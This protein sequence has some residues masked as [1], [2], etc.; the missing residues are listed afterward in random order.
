MQSILKTS[1]DYKQ[2]ITTI[3]WLGLLSSVY[4]L[5]T[6][7]FSFGVLLISEYSVITKGMS[8]VQM[9]SFTNRYT[10]FQE[11]GLIPVYFVAIGS[12]ITSLGLIKRKEWA[13]IMSIRIVWGI[14]A[15]AVLFF[16]SK[17]SILSA[18]LPESTPI[19]TE[20]DIIFSLWGQFTLMIKAGIVATFITYVFS[21]PRFKSCF[22]PGEWR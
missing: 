4:F 21:I 1:E 11:I 13:R 12:L 15:L 9:E 8:N 20:T 17:Y 14:V 16:A 19:G 2:L 18:L 6:S 10:L 22:E 7:A 3:G 5:S